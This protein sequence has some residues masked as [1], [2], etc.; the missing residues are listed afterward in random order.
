MA[1]Q[2]CLFEDI[3][4]LLIEA[5]PLTLGAGAGLLGAIEG[6]GI[7]I[8]LADLGWLTVA[9]HAGSIT[10]MGCS[11]VPARLARSSPGARVGSLQERPVRKGCCGT[12]D[13]A[14]REGGGGVGFTLHAQAAVLLVADEELPRH[15]M[16][17]T[18]PREPV[19]RRFRALEWI[20]AGA[21]R[22]GGGTTH[23][24]DRKGGSI[25]RSSVFRRSETRRYVRDQVHE[26]SM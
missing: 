4:G 22:A 16:E 5:T 2:Q 23:L 6:I 3:D 11:S 14:R 7:E 18:G 21:S 17:R 25:R 9:A 10:I 1:A 13:W 26:P 15:G 19:V 12:A 24:M 8:S 20:S